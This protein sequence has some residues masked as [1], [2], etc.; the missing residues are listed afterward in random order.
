MGGP[1]EKLMAKMGITVKDTSGQM[2]PLNDILTALAPHANDVGVQFELLGT[3]GGNAGLV[4]GAVAQDARKLTG[5]LENAGGTAQSMADIMAGGLWGSLKAIAS[6]VDSAYIS[7]GQ[8]FAPVLQ[9]VADLFAKLPSPIQEV[10]VVVG[11]LAGAMGGLM[12][13]M[14]GVFGAIVTLPG[15]LVALTAK[16]SL[17]TF[18]VKGLTLAIK[19]AWRAL[20]GPVGWVIAI[21]AATLGL[22]K[23]WKATNE[24]D[25]RL[26]KFE[27]QL[28]ATNSRLLEFADTSPRLV[29]E[30]GYQKEAIERQIAALKKSHP[31][32]EQAEEDLAALADA[33]S[34]LVPEL[35]PIPPIIRETGDAAAE[36]AVAVQDLVDPVQDLIDTW[37]G[38][39]L[40]SDEFLAAFEALTPEMRD[41]DRIMDQVLT[42]YDAMR[43]VLGPFND[44]LEALWRATERLNPTLES[45]TDQV[46]ALMRAQIE[47][48]DALD[49]A[50][51][52]M[53]TAEASATKLDV[54]LASLAGQMGGAAGQSL[55]L[56]A[57]MVQTNKNLKE[58]EEG[59]SRVQIGAATAASGFHMLGDA[60]GGTGGAILSA[61]GD[62]ASA[63]AT[64]G[65]VAGIMAGVGA[66]IK[67]IMSMG[68]P[69]EAELEARETF[70][71]FHKGAVDVLGGTEEFIDLVQ[72]HVADGWDRTN[73]ETLSGFIVWGTQ[74]GLTYDQ[75]TAKYAQYEK[76]VRDG[77]TAMMAQ[78]DAEFAEYRQTAEET[79][80]A[81]A[82]AWEKATSAVISAFD[83]AKKAGTDAYDKIFLAAIESGAS[84]EE[85]IKK[86]TAAQEEASAKVLAIEKD[87]FIR[88]ARFEAALLAIR[89]GNAEGA[90]EAADKAARETAEAWDISLKAVTKADDIASQKMQTNSAATADKAILEAERMSAGVSAELDRI[91]HRGRFPSM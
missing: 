62:V 6:I 50:G 73:A 67:G 28:E 71:G 55:N 20:M 16:I 49:D 30:L 76:A 82:A 36:T 14:P 63:F 4:L 19:T 59:F 32:L 83:R 57:A 27:K 2:L 80:A 1:A 37:T 38:A 61:I 87:K 8:R 23:F 13:L 66:I 5:E 77:N 44:E 79:T 33:S 40:K 58:G 74:A 22:Y 31:E 70:A 43:K 11:S 78:L 68:G 88:I 45:S 35:A 51:A 64:G 41:N 24:P 56:V 72:A 89:S 21:A 29:E 85:A 81:A 47:A 69:S 46:D 65:L 90:T 7:F 3:R 17:T 60:I 12:I 48:T 10:V 42:K 54:T 75:S 25:K 84:Q 86:A 15:K 18:S 53:D 34:D 91:P 52:E 26:A 9:K 39:T